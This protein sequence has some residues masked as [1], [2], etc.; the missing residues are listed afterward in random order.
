MK[1]IYPSL[2]VLCILILILAAFAAASGLWWPG[3]GESF[4]FESI[5]GESVE[6]QGSGLYYYDSVSAAAQAKAQDI[7][8]L[9]VG[10]PLLVIGLIFYRKGSLRGALLLT[11]TLGYFLYTY[12]SLTFLAMFNP[13]FLVYVAL[14]TLSLFA[15]IQSVISI[16]VQ[17]LPGRFTEKLPRTA[18]ATLMFVVAGFL[19]LAWLGRILPAVLN[20]TAPYGLEAYTTLV[21]QALD[22]GLVVPFSLV[23]GILLLRKNRF[24]YL[25]SSVML[26]K[27]ITMGTAVSAM[28]IGMIIRGVPVS[29]VE[30]VVFP[31][32]TVATI[33][34]TVILFRH[35]RPAPKKIRH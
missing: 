31:L 7:V 10:I 9:A 13:L 28:A 11:G 18:I 23:G 20:G 14:F 34:M 22:L 19:T 27:G 17:N 16:D 29:P 35:I 32:I 5:R 15:L 30:T 1:K 2:T 6:I 25:V 12:T 21:I 24:G 26:F 4:T 33:I 3:E 8:T